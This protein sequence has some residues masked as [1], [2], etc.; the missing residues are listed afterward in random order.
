M[1][2]H[3]DNGRSFSLQAKTR[4]NNYFHNWND[5]EDLHCLAS[6][7]KTQRKNEPNMAEEKR[8]L[9]TASAM[10]F[11]KKKFSIDAMQ[12]VEM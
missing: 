9:F 5:S 8:L 3:N 10:H 2:N 12:V 7:K 11:K 6:A 1:Y 4:C